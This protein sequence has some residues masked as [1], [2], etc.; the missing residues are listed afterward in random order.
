MVARYTAAT[1]TVT[2]LRGSHRYTASHCYSSARLLMTA[3]FS[4]N[5]FI[6]YFVTLPLCFSVKV[7][8]TPQG[9]PPV[10]IVLFVCLCFDQL[11]IESGLPR[12]V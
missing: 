5:I 11:P 10:H 12:A 1:V 8:L 2:Q 6:A 3:I 7:C 4:Q 9:E